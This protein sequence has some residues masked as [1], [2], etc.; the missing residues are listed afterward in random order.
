MA[1][2]FLFTSQVLQLLQTAMAAD[3]LHLRDLE[4]RFSGSAK[5]LSPVLS[6]IKDWHSRMR[7]VAQEGF[8]ALEKS[9]QVSRETRTFCIDLHAVSESVQQVA[10]G[11]E[12]LEVATDNISM[13]VEFTSK[14]SEEGETKVKEGNVSCSALLG[15][16]DLLENSI[17]GM[18][19]TMGKFTGFAKEIANLTSIV[20]SIAHQTN[21][22]ALNAAIEAARA[23]EAGRGFA[24]V[25]DEVKQ[26]ADKTAQ[27]TTEIEH[28]TATMNQLT[29]NVTISIDSSLDRVLKSTDAMEG[30]VM[31]LADIHS[32]MSTVSNSAQEI[33]TA[34]TDQRRIAH[35]IA[36]QIVQI[37]QTQ[38]NQRAKIKVITNE[39]YSAT[40]SNCAQLITFG[41]W[42]DDLVL[43][44]AIKGAHMA[45]MSEMDEAIFNRTTTDIS[46]RV[47]T[48]T[49]CRLGHWLAERGRDRYGNTSSFQSLCE[50]HE[51]VHQLGKEIADLIRNSDFNTASVKIP[52]LDARMTDMFRYIDKLILD[53]E[54]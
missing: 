27:A 19:S 11:L 16:L 14:T 46:D 32:A 37:N 40:E 6:T 48:A 9:N 25:A 49:T 36:S 38:A 24:V 20:R 15:E 41:Y 3:K 13:Q 12:K 5:A 1:G 26:L 2:P 22:L 7:E 4:N 34:S 33:A 52:T 23:G 51:Q 18:E 50:V 42:D 44:R 39:S 29:S 10:H 8:S 54:T 53:A 17:R 31:A 43:L 30:V 35:E 45:W 47:K 21:L 28:V